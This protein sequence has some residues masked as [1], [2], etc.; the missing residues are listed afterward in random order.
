[1]SISDLRRLRSSFKTKQPLLALWRPYPPLDSASLLLPRKDRHSTLSNELGQCSVG[2]STPG[3]VNF[4]KEYS[5]HTD[6]AAVVASRKSR[7]C[8]VHNLNWFGTRT[9]TQFGGAERREG[10]YQ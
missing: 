2:T 3:S 5:E 6:V 4:H 9:A 10:V 7:V 8:D 1:M